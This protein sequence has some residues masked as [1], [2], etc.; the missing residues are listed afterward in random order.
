MLRG[1]SLGKDIVLIQMKR[2][3]KGQALVEF[4]IILPIILMILFIIIDFSNIFYQKNHLE[5]T[6]NDVVEYKENGKSNS[7][8]KDKIND[9]SISISY[10]KIDDSLDIKITKKVNLITPFSSLFFDN[11]FVIKTERMILYE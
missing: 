4:V 10:K 3:S 9:S 5:S 11:P 2:N 6:L 8:I 7:Y 1:I